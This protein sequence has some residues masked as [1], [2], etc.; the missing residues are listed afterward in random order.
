MWNAEWGMRNVRGKRHSAFRI[1]HSAL[2]NAPAT[3]ARRKAGV[4]AVCVAVSRVRTRSSRT[5]HP[6]RGARWRARRSLWLYPRARS[7]RAANGIGTRVAAAISGRETRAIAAVRSP[8]IRGRPPYLSAW[9]ALRAGGVEPDRRSGAVQR[10]WPI[11]ADTAQ[12]E[13]GLRLAAPR[14]PGG[15]DGTPAMPA[16]LA[17]E[18]RLGAV[19]REQTVAQQTLSRQDELLEGA[20]HARRD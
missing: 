3:F 2:E 13:R 6:H 4:N 17:D 7:R 16:H 10:L 14:A 19:E 8:A 18:G 12:A 5:G 9:T 1:P 15:H 20:T 11:V